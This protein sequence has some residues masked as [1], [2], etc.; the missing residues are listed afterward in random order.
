MKVAIL[1][2]Q[3]GNL[4]SV[5]QACLYLGIDSFITSD[6]KTI[7]K[8]DAMILPGV[9]AFGDAMGNLNRMDLVE[10]IKDFVASKKPFMGVCLGL[11]L[12][13]SESEEFGNSKG[14]NMIDGF[15]KKF[16]PLDV[17]GDRLKIP[18]IAWNSIHPNHNLAWDGTPLSLCSPED[19]MYFIHSFYV[20]PTSNDIILSKSNY[21]GYEYCSSVLKDNIF[22]CQFH[23]EKSGLKGI[24]IYKNWLNNKNIK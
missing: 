5:N 1:D 16:N 18:Q 4:F 20:H 23:P 13:F 7:L 8:A 11:Q 17:N 10:P 24:Q 22:A 3:L 9:G 21:G 6:A 2:Y 15:V 19:Y 12:L 14:L